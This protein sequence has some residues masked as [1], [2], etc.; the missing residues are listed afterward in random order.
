MKKILK[1]FASVIGAIA[2]LAE[3]FRLVNQRNKIKKK[4]KQ[5][6]WSLVKDKAKTQNNEV[7]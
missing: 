4:R 1:I 3:V 7:D 6:H 2:V 5:S